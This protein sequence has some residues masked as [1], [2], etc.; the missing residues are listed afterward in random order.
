[1][2]ILLHSLFQAEDVTVMK[3][4]RRVENAYHVEAEVCTELTGSGLAGGQREFIFI[5]E[6]KCTGETL[7]MY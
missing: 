2:I 5:T 4:S 6:S 3:D 7:L 1:M